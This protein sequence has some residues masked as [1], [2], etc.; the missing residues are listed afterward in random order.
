MI[1][2]WLQR[3]SWGHQHPLCIYP[4]LQMLPTTPLSVY[5]KEWFLC[6]QKNQGS[7]GLVETSPYGSSEY[8]Y[9]LR[10]HEN[11]WN[12]ASTHT[13]L[14]GKLELLWSHVKKSRL[15]IVK[16]HIFIN[17]RNYG[18]QNYFRSHKKSIKMVF[19]KFEKMLNF[20]HNKWNTN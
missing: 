3:I 11:F 12:N 17:F 5:L 2:S 20:T 1:W 7:I 13:I 14:L 4:V 19:E 9:S 8:N 18:K 10:H 6:E 15:D 16:K